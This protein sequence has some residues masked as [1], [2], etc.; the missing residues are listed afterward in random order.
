MTKE[1][2]IEELMA[3]AS[4]TARV[5][6]KS[7]QFLSII[8]PTTIAFLILFAFGCYNIVSAKIVGGAFIVFIIILFASG[9][10]LPF[11]KIS[12]EK[13][14]KYFQEKLSVRLKET[15]R[16]LDNINIQKLKLEK[17]LKLLKEV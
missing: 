7:R 12:E 4:E 16:Y 3:K 17:E 10:F 6:K 15:Q 2:L 9:N 8:I 14:N 13:I 1:K 11:G 5:E